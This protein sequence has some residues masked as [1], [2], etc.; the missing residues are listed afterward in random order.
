M[1]LTFERKFKEAFKLPPVKPD[2]RKLMEMLPPRP[3][4]NRE[5]NRKFLK[6]LEFCFDI[7][8]SETVKQEVKNSLSEYAKVI[9]LLIEEYEKKEFPV[10]QA[11]PSE[12]LAF[13]MEEHQLSQS[14]LKKEL[15]G[16]SVVSE[17]LNGKRKLNVKQ[18]EHLSKRFHTS[19]SVF[20]QNTR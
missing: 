6:V 3:I 7:L 10:P 8:Q 2:Y 19:P 17:I 4:K 20:F 9:G 15:G 5:E 18:I 11:S 13:F 14:D 1:T 12:I 16:Q